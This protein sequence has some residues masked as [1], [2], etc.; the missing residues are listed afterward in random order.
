[1]SCVKPLEKGTAKHAFRDAAARAKL[2]GVTP[3]TLRHTAAT[4]MAQEGVPVWDIAGLL[5][6]T[7][8][9]VEEVYGHH[10]P[11]HLRR[12]TRSLG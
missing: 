9:M 2:P 12:A 6:N 4:W 10:S 3:H 5:G 8:Q 7:V 11:D 1:L